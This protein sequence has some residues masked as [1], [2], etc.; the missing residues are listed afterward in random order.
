MLYFDIMR[1]DYEYGYLQYIKTNDIKT[2]LQPIST[3]LKMNIAINMCSLQ[4]QIV[5]FIPHECF[6]KKSHL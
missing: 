1:I 6:V 3:F 4:I 5:Y 2:Y